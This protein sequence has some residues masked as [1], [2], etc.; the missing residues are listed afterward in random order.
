MDNALTVLF[1]LAVVGLVAYLVWRTF[2]RKPRK[3]VRDLHLLALQKWLGG[4][5]DGAAVL[6]ESVIRQQP[7]AVD[8]YLQLG[9]LLRMKGD[10]RRASALHRGL[11]VRPDL[12]LGTRIQVGLSLAEDLIDLKQFAEAGKVLDTLARHA[13]GESRY[14]KS[15][16][17]QWYGLGE[18]PDA[19]RALKYARTKVPPADVAWFDRAYVAFQ[20]DRALMHAIEGET[21]DAQARLKDVAKLPGAAERAS[22]V[23][24]ILAARGGDVRAALDAASSDLLDHPRELDLFLPFLQEILYSQGQYEKTIPLLERACQGEGAPIRMVVDLAVLY[25]KLGQRDKAVQLIT[26]KAGNPDLTPAAAVPVLRLLARNTRDEDFRQVWKAL[27][28]PAPHQHWACGTCGMTSPRIR[29]FCP[30]CRS[31]QS[32]APVPAWGKVT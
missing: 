8:P 9:D 25:D 12:P 3:Q 24:A 30:R 22:L 18:L 1:A 4:D 16:F 14:W 20:L 27:S 29:W 23:H 7:D 21:G 31:F 28:L 5:L 6:L 17:Q 15:R 13:T 2:E 11:T 26:G 32:Y 19:A 10:P